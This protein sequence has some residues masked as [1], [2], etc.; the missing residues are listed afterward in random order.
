MYDSG[1]RHLNQWI[2]YSKYLLSCQNNFSRGGPDTWQHTRYRG[3]HLYFYRE[4]VLSKNNRK[5]NLLVSQMYSSWIV[6][7]GQEGILG[8]KN[9]LEESAG[10]DLNPD[11]L[12]AACG[13][14]KHPRLE[15]EKM[16]LAAMPRLVLFLCYISHLSNRYL[17]VAIL[18]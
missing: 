15:G 2:H 1:R 3:S 5:A 12:N 18:I 10:L 4:I 11:P 9:E 6:N 14:S 8:A 16:T 13:P 7:W 17:H